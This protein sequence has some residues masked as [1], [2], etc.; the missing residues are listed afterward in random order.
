MQLLS[1]EL[2]TCQTSLRRSEED[3]LTTE[4]DDGFEDLES[5]GA[6]EGGRRADVALDLR[7]DKK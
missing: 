2:K 1:E 3:L 5:E 7:R 6:E 4:G